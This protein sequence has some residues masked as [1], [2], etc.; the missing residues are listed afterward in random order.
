MNYPLFGRYEILETDQNFLHTRD[1]LLYKG[2]LPPSLK[3]DILRD[4]PEN[5][6]ENDK[7]TLHGR[8][9]LKNILQSLEKKHYTP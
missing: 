8:H 5:W 3:A 2:E 9:F 4:F 6:F 1:E 7:L